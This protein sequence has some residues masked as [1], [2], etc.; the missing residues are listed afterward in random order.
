MAE[1]FLARARTA[2]G[3]MERHVVLK[4]IRPERGDDPLW[5]TMFLDEA[6]L[7]AQ[8]QHPNVAQV[9]DLG[10]IGDTYF[11]TMEYVHGE[12]VRGVLSRVAALGDRLPVSIAIAIACGTAAGLHHAHERCA[13]DNSP[14]GIVHRDVS[15]SNIIVG[16]EG[17][18]KVVDF[19]VAKAAKRTAD[20][21]VGTIMGKLA[22]LSPEQSL[23]LP[24]DHR[25]DIFSLGIVLYEMLTSTRVFRVGND[26][27][28]LSAIVHHQPPP[29][30]YWNQLLPP[31]LDEV[32]MTALEKDPA[33]RFA[34]CDQMLDALEAIAE[35]ASLPTSSTTLRRFM[36]DLFGHRPEPWRELD[37]I[38]PAATG[39]VTFTGTIEPEPASVARDPMPTL[40][41]FPPDT[42][43]ADVPLLSAIRTQLI[44]RTP[45]LHEAIA[46]GSGQLAVGRPLPMASPDGAEGTVTIWS[47]IARR[48]L[49]VIALVT[50]ATIAIAI[51]I[52]IGLSGDSLPAEPARAIA[53]PPTAIE[54]KGLAPVATPPVA[55]PDAAVEIVAPPIAIPAV[56]TPSSSSSSKSRTRRSPKPRDKETGCTDPLKCQH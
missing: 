44:T 26:V 22:Y 43:A 35:R 41:W 24:L 47:S 16:Y 49:L 11:F 29:P 31:G 15:P 6:R 48:R 52:Y 36:R 12:N 25:S 32:V 9:F 56:E 40:A 33:R 5:V 20:T 10:Q 2:T 19:G 14:L 8:L 34:S 45:S 38:A 30:S 46:R 18:V 50:A 17:T 21:A 23:G 28:T 13:S 37:V 51:A 54:S 1:I 53:N 39:T 55:M 4:R 7:A 27:D 3:G 42:V